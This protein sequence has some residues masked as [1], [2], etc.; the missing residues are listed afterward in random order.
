MQVLKSWF[1]EKEDY[2]KRCLVVIIPDFELFNQN[3]LLDLISVLTTYRSELP[4]FLIIGVATSVSALINLLPYHITSKIQFEVLKTLESTTLLNS[5]IHDVLLSPFCPFRLSGKVLKHLIDVFLFFDFSINSFIKG[6]NYCMLEHF[7][8]GDLYSLCCDFENYKTYPNLKSI[9][10]TPIFRNKI[11]KASPIE[12]I[13]LLT[14]DSHFRDTLKE[15]ITDVHIYYGNLHSGLLVLHSFVHDLPNNPIGKQ[16]REVYSY[17]I[18]KNILELQE[19]N[20]VWKLL[21]FLSKKEIL[22]KLENSITKLYSFRKTLAQHPHLNTCSKVIFE[23]S[24]KLKEFKET[25]ELAGLEVKT[26]YQP[27]KMQQL[28]SR[29][30]LKDHLLERSKQ[31]KTISEYS[32]QVN[33]CLEYIKN[34][35]ITKLILPF[36]S[37]PDFLNYFV[38]SDLSTVK[39]HIIGAPRRAIN[40]ALSN[41]HQYLQCKCCKLD[42]SMG[43]IGTLPDISIVYK[44][45]LECGSLINLF[46][47]LQAFRSIV[48][49]SEEEIDYMDPTI[50]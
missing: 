13:L 14:K 39:D 27:P 32:K 22:E 2:E 46:D 41:P 10:N 33:S 36:N 19:F 43:C 42:N 9:L 47:W 25:I 26:D 3:V 35:I 5:I 34:E 20:E 31:P 44:L 38:F 16:F 18:S 29:S 8:K 12:A 6:L 30:E 15:S 24:K 11:E 40:M 7:L 50:L 48:D 21:S 17:A 4:L 1:F 49:Y 23:I 45:H 37:G 28:F